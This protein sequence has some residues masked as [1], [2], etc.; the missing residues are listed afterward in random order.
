MKNNITQE[1]LIRYHYQETSVAESQRISRVLTISPSLQEEFKQISET[2]QLLGKDMG[3]PSQSS[4]D[5]IMD[6]TNTAET[7]FQ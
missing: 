2:L 6:A 7:E 5:I 1:D 4:I 3:G